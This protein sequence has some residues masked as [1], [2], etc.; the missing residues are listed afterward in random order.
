MVVEWADGREVER[1]LLPCRCIWT[2]VL[3][4]LRGLASNA[5]VDT[6]AISPGGIHG[7]IG[8]AAQFGVYLS[9]R[10]GV[11]TDGGHLEVAGL[12]VWLM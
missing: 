12:V 9:Y 10:G 4:D 6:G 5:H 1:F 2:D 3:A 11:R 7:G 8:L